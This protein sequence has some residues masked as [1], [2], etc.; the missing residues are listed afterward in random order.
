MP[1]AMIK[2]LAADFNSVERQTMRDFTPT[3]LNCCKQLRRSSHNSP[4]SKK[5]L[6]KN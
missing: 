1:T 2:E 3:K 6:Y 4:F 5:T